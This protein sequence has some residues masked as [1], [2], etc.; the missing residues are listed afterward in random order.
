MR[1][2]APLGFG[3]I[4]LLLVLSFVFKQDFLSLVDTGPGRMMESASTS[5]DVPFQT[6]SQ[7][8]RR[9]I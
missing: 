2:A 8:E 4:L 5:T 9:W 7:E 6:T 1:R 3:G